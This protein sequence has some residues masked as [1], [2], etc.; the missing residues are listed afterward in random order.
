[1]PEIWLLRT[2]GNKYVTMTSVGGPIETTDNANLAYSWD[3][4]AAAE[5]AAEAVKQSAGIESVPVRYGEHTK[6]PRRLGLVKTT[7]LAAGV[8]LAGAACQ[9]PVIFEDGSWYVPRVGEND[10][11]GAYVGG[12]I[13]GKLCDDTPGDDTD[14][15]PT[16]LRCLTRLECDRVFG[17]EG[18]W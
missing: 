3:S 16:L 2:N 8:V 10:P 17:P 4:K 6:S 14:N 13:S 18:G 12:C 9:A 11:T 5:K 1:M 15:Q 7:I